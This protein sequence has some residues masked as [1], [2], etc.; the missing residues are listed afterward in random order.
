MNC[1]LCPRNCNIDRTTKHGFCA[2][3]NKIKIARAALHMWEEPCITGS[4][5]SG[6]IFFSGCNLG[7]VYCQNKAI[8]NGLSGKEISA[9]RLYEIFFELKDKGAENINLV[10][11]THY[12]DKIL[13]V[14][15][16]AQL[17]DLNIPIVYNTSS[18]EKVDIIKKLNKSIDIYLPDLK[19]MS[20]ELSKN[21]SGAENYFS[22]AEKAIEE[23]VLQTGK[24]RF[25]KNGKL[26]GGVIVRHLVLPE[27]IG[28]AKRII[29]Y[30]HSKYGDDIYISIMNQ[31]TPMTTSEKYPELMRKL[32]HD[33]Y[34]RVVDYALR[35]GLKNAYIQDKTAAAESFIP[36]FDC[37]GV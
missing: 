10:T 15:N 17:N 25:D 19:Y 4:G 21:L 8:S 23:M 28:E 31:Y 2:V 1:T 24:C 9:R 6:T 33:E 14:I 16:Q 3:G 13:P 18:Y 35:I 5:G 37:E 34:E 20:S 11:A 36:Q 29:K 7:C 12:A 32:T 22:V 26:L 30:L 27:H